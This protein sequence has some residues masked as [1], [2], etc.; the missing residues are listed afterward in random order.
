MTEEALLLAAG[1]LEQKSEHP[2]ARASLWS[3]AKERGMDCGDRLSLQAVPGNGLTGRRGT[4]FLAG[5]NAAFIGGQA[6][7]PEAAKAMAEQY[8]K[9][10][11]TPLFFS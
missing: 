9:Q 3:M 11:K 10:G 4:S 1:A 6:T 5:G 2:L 8:A 7:I